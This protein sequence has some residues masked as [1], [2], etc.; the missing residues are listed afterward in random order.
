MIYLDRFCVSKATLYTSRQLVPGRLPCGGKVLQ[1]IGAFWQILHSSLCSSSGN[2][3][4]TVKYDT[5]V[6]GYTNG[7]SGRSEL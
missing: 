1:N 3:N 4:C 6:S 5:I 7:V 2:Y